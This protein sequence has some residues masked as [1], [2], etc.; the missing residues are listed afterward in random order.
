MIKEKLRLLIGREQPPSQN[1]LSQYDF[2]HRTPPSGCK[3]GIDAFLAAHDGLFELLE[4][5][6][7][8]LWLRKTAAVA[9]APY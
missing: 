5:P 2:R 9:T 1:A 7:Y 4:P 3:R 6:T 8:Q